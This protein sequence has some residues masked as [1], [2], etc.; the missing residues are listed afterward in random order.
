[1]A[2]NFPLKVSFK[3]GE[4]EICWNLEENDITLE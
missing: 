1:M 4:Y 2:E 3:N